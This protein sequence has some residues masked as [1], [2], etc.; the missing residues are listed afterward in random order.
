MDRDK[1]RLYPPSPASQIA[2]DDIVRGMEPRQNLVE[3]LNRR[4]RQLINEVNRLDRTIELLEKNAAL[5]EVVEV[6]LLAQG[7]AEPFPI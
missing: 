7:K 3:R 4:R 2:T 1:E 5:V 6:V